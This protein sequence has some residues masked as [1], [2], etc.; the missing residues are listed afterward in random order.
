[1]QPFFSECHVRC[2]HYIKYSSIDFFRMEKKIHKIFPLKKN[3]FLTKQ[4]FHYEEVRSNEQILKNERV[5]FVI[6]ELVA[7]TKCIPALNFLLWKYRSLKCF[8]SKK[9]LF[10]NLK[11]NFLMKN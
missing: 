3:V 7:H 2:S 1:M 8:N 5:K 4:K 6:K 11:K 9:N 10:F